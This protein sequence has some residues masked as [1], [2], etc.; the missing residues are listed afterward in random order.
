[1]VEALINIG[2]PAIPAML[3]NVKTAK[4]GKK[5]ELSVMVING[6]ERP[7]VA[8]EDHSPKGTLM[9]RTNL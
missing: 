3:E 8:T 6:V 4:G 9:R 1:M 2:R 7:I 5:T